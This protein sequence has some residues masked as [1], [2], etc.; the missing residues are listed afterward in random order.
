MTYRKENLLNSTMPAMY[1]PHPIKVEMFQEEL[2]K[3]TKLK[4]MVINDFET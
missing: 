1:H 4:K 3:I 2:L